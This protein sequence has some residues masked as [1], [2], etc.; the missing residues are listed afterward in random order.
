MKIF[1]TNKRIS[2]MTLL[3]DHPLIQYAVIMLKTFIFNKPKV[4]QGNIANGRYIATG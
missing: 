4:Y 1:Q 2:E 3:P